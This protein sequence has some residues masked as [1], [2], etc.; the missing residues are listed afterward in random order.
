M[1]KAYVLIEI[2]GGQHHQVCKRIREFQEHV[3][4]AD[5]IMGPFDLI[6]IVTGTDADEIGR[7]V[8]NEI[9]GMEQVERTLTCVV[10]EPN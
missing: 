7:F 8:I 10:I 6:T 9:Q 3:I 2:K 5:V 4:T 1:V